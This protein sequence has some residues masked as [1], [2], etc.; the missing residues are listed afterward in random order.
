MSFSLKSK[1]QHVKGRCSRCR[2]LMYAEEIS[3]RAEAYTATWAPDRHY[4][5]DEEADCSSIEIH[6]PRGRGT[7]VSPVKSGQARSYHQC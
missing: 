4:L 3:R 1:K 7:G 5:T 6:A 2:W